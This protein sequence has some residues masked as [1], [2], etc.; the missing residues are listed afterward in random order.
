MK[1]ILIA[2]LTTGITLA[3]L[4]LFGQS[5]NASAKVSLQTSYLAVLGP[6]NSSTSGSGPIE[7]PWTTVLEQ[8]IKIPNNYD[9]VIVPS[10]EVGLLTSTTVNS[11]NMV[12]DTT[13]ATASVKVRVLVDG[14]ECAPGQVV[15]GKRT[16]E[17]S[18]TLE[19]A[20]AGCLSIVTN[21]SGALTIV[22]NTNC[23]QPEV[24]SLLQDTVSANSFTFAA[25]NQLVG[26]HLVQVQAK[27]AAMGDNQNGKFAARA[28]LGKGTL[29]IE[30][31]RLAKVSR[32]PYVLQ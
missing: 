1:S 23:V 28:L 18:A 31:S 20:I 16:Q 4:S 25:I 3:A 10:F 17:L 29:T 9:L 6:V 13:T 8:S 22:L 14:K 24:V 15:Y 32:E 7:T 27:I 26:P 21:D 5:V 2:G 12:T 19:G 11:K 30:S